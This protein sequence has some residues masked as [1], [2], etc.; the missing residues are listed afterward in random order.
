MT[1]RAAW[2]AE[3]VPPLFFFV[4]FRVAFLR[5]AVHGS[6]WRV[7]CHAKYVLRTAS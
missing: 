1:P 6:F 5:V 3:P 7:R 2:P 4:Y